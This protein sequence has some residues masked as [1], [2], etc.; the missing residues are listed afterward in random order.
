MNVITIPAAADINYLDVDEIYGYQLLLCKRFEQAGGFDLPRKTN[1]TI[2]E[3]QKQGFVWLRAV[4]RT[5]EDILSPVNETGMALDAIPKLVDAYEFFYRVCNNTSAFSFIRKVRLKTAEYWVKGNNTITETDVVLGILRE[6][7][8]DVRTLD[9]KY[10]QYAYSV[11]DRWI[12]ELC[13]NGKFRNVTLWEAYG[14]LSYLIQ[15]DLFA[16]F[17]NQAVVK[18]NWVRTYSLSDDE[19]NLLYTATLWRYIAFLNNVSF[20]SDMPSERYDELY[21]SNISRLLSRSDLHPFVREAL[22]LDL[23]NYET[24]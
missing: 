24:A 9:N 7:R 11:K 13:K 19:M 5:I 3:V 1:F 22:E 16:Y 17:N 21:V 12:E 23:S 4:K 20:M 6:V 14:R 2:L 18:A 10:S 15:S 8:R